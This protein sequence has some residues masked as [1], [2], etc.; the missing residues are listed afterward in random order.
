MKLEEAC[1]QMCNWC[2]LAFCNEELCGVHAIKEFLSD[3]LDDSFE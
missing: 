2:P 1:D 3:R